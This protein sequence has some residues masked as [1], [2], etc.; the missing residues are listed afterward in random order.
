[1]RFSSLPS[2]ALAALVL[3]ACGGGGSASNTG[4]SAPP[5]PTWLQRSGAS[6]EVVDLEVPDHGVATVDV[7]TAQWSGPLGAL[8]P[9]AA[10]A[11]TRDVLAVSVPEL[12]AGIYD[13][14]VFDGARLVAL[15]QIEH[16]GV[17]AVVDPT[18][19]VSSTLTEL[20]SYID[21]LRARVLSGSLPADLQGFVDEASQR[22]IESQQSL[23]TASS[24][25][26][27]LVAAALAANGEYL[28]SLAQ[29][30]AGGGLPG[31]C[32]ARSDVS[33]IQSLDAAAPRVAAALA[34]TLLGEGLIADAGSAAGLGTALG[35]LVL[36]VSLA[37]AFEEVHRVEDAPAVFIGSPIVV[38]SASDGPITVEL[39]TPFTVGL[40]GDCRT[41]QTSDLEAGAPS[42]L[43]SI[44]AS[45]EDVFGRTAGLVDD[46][47]ELLSLPASVVPAA[48]TLPTSG[49]ASRVQMDG[50]SV[51][52]V[53]AAQ[54]AGGEP[55]PLAFG[56]G[57]GGT[58]ALTL[59]G[60][61]VQDEIQIAFGYEQTG[62]SPESMH[63]FAVQIGAT[64]QPIP[65]MVPIPAGTFL[66]GSNTGSS[67]PYFNTQY[68]SPVHMVTIST[69]FWM[70]QCE[71]T[72]AEYEE[73]MGTNPSLFQGSA[74]PVESVTWHEATAYC[75]ALT[76]REAGR[77]PVG[78]EYRLP[79][80]AEW[81][82]ACRAGT[83]TEFNVGAE[84]VCG[85]AWM[86]YSTHTQSNCDQ[87]GVVGTLPVGSFP[88][89]AF[90]LFDMHGNVG[91]WCCDLPLQYTSAPVTDPFSLLGAYKVFRG[92]S[93]NTSSPECRSAQRASYTPTRSHEWLGF[94]VV[95]AR[96]LVP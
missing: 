21:G 19:L 44:V 94:R 76:A 63:E 1:M 13:V 57:A 31:D 80:E 53:T 30:P 7:L 87:G 79:T 28:A 52:W 51:R 23:G 64:T 59:Q 12:A 54:A 60:G 27:S 6:H 93:W 95:L 66:M 33:A 70:G 15:G 41:V 84:L 32:P 26:V 24:A 3:S 50:G 58:L 90:G 40:A 2:C 29:N 61:E 74:R 56:L 96:R 88:P 11:L 89:N 83:T 48:P 39:N 43:R 55:V 49:A 81:E 14:R 91:E 82:Y 16:T 5:P 9:S 78:F 73:M 72:Q 20:E 86:S 46:V 65:G 18:A 42:L 10:R 22:N 62:I 92:G 36:F 34:G 77:I 75:A 47:V 85:Q 37:R 45:I 25:V 71:V 17:V 4:A 67:W 35:E 38:C 69:A 8:G 68:Q